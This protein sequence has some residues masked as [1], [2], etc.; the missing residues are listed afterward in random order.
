MSDPTIPLDAIVIEPK[1]S[2]RNSHS[3]SINVSAQCAPDENKSALDEDQEPRH[4]PARTIDTFDKATLHRLS[5]SYFLTTWSVRMDE[6]A[7]ALFLSYIFPHTLLTVSLYGFLVTLFAI[8]FSSTVG[9]VVDKVPRLKAIRIFLVL[10]NLCIAASSLVL[11]A[12]T[13]RFGL[14]VNRTMTYIL[15]S[16]SLLL[17]IALRLANIGEVVS[18]ERDWV[19]VIAH[20]DTSALSSMNAYLRRIDLLCKVAAPLVVSGIAEALSTPIAMLVTAGWSILTAPLQWWLIWQV[21]RRVPALAIPKTARESTEQRADSSAVGLTD[22]DPSVNHSSPVASSVR[23]CWDQW[24]RFFRHPVFLSSLAIAQLYMTVLSFGPVMISYLLAQGYS[25]ALLAGMRSIAVLAGISATIAMPRMVARI[26]L[27]RTG[28]W[29]IWSELWSLVPVVISFWMPVGGVAAGVMMFAGTTLSR[30][31]LW[32]F[33]MTQMQIMQ[34]RV[35]AAESGVINGMQY[36][37]QNFFELLAF[38]TTIVWNDTDSFY[39][40]A[41][42]TAAAVASGSLTYSV[43]ALRNRGHLFHFEKLARWGISPPRR[44]SGRI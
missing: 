2:T 27:V 25:S 11:Y 28:L 31:G 38:M 37:M 21:Y 1:E 13:L 7:T 34:E 41:I 40:P 14:N 33:D 17:G 9:S 44:E 4:D 32:T 42:L 22:V 30:F 16:G 26:G 18:V 39:I 15:Y 12:I 10:Q 24:A 5:M 3:S 23:S 36:S 29:A 43:F 6:W 20:A 8:L 19:V 35:D